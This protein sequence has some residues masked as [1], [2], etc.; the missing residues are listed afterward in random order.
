MM[1][2]E[3]GGMPHLVVLAPDSDRDRRIPLDGVY[4]VP[5]RKPTCDVRFD[6]PGV[7]RANAALQ[8]RELR[9]TF[10]TLAPPAGT[11]VNGATD[12]SSGC[13][14]H[15]PLVTNAQI[16]IPATRLGLQRGQH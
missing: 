10:K 1:R 12:L 9:S 11:F 3:N 5:G 6:D 4:M 14:P 15:R 2:L 13:A 16:A 7:S 8:P